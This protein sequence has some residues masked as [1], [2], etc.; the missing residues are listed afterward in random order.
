MDYDVA[1]DVSS[2]VS[3]LKENFFPNGIWLLCMATTIMLPTLLQLALFLYSG[4]IFL[5]PREQLNVIAE[6]L[7]NAKTVYEKDVLAWKISAIDVMAR[8]VFAAIFLAVVVATI[9]A[10]LPLGQVVIIWLIESAVVYG[11]Q[12]ASWVLVAW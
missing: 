4:L 5:I 10:T 3:S 9:Q 11:S 2:M 12:S 1:F 8:L 6:A 7:N